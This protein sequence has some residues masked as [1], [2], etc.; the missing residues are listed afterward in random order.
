MTVRNINLC[1]WNCQ[2]AKSNCHWLLKV[3]DNFDII[4]IQETWLFDYEN[5]LLKFS[6][7]HNVIA[8]SSMRNDKKLTGR[9]FGG[10]AFLIKT[11]L[12]S[13]IKIVETND[14]RLLAITVELANGDNLLVVNVYF[15]VNCAN[16][17][18][19]I[20]EYIAKTNALIVNHSGPV[21]V[22]G[23]LNISEKHKNFAELIEFCKSS[24]CHLIDLERLSPKTV[25]YESQSHCSSSWID[26]IIITANLL[27]KVQKVE[28]LYEATPSDHF[29]LTIS[30]HINVNRESTTGRIANVKSK[31]SIVN[32]K[33]VPP[34]VIQN[35]TNLTR[36]NISKI[37]KWELCTN[38][39]CCNTEHCQNIDDISLLLTST[40]LSHQNEVFTS[41]I[42][43]QHTSRAY[44]KVGWNDQVKVKYQDYRYWFLKWTSSN[45]KDEI[46][47]QQMKVKRKAFKTALK[48]IRQKNET[49]LCDKLATSYDDN[50]FYEFWKNVKSTKQTSSPTTT[51]IENANGDNQIC[52]M[53][54]THYENIFASSSKVEHVC[55]NKHCETSENWKVSPEEIVECL[56]QL[57]NGKAAGIDGL[58]A[59]SY[60]F[61]SRN[62][63]SVIANIFNS[64][65]A[66][67][68]LPSEI[69]KFILCPILKKPSLDPTITKNYRP[70][71]LA[72]V[73]SKVFELLILTRHKVKFQ[74]STSQFG[75]KK[76]VGT[77][78]AIFTLKQVAHHYLRKGSPVY[79]CY[80]DA[81][82]A[83]DN[84]E[85]SKLLCKLC[86]RNVGRDTI[87]LLKFWFNNQQ[88]LC[89][90][91][92]I[93]SDPFY[94][95]KATR[96]G[97]IISPYYFA[98][99]MENL[100]LQL[101]K[102]GLGCKVGS[103]SCNHII[104]ADDVALM[105]TSISSL[106]RMLKLCE[107]F[108]V[109][110][111]ITFNPSK[112]ILQ[113]FTPKYMDYVRPLVKFCGKN[114]Q[115]AESVKY[116]GYDICCWDRDKNELVKRKREIYMQANL[117]KSFFKKCSKNVKKYLFT[118]YFSSIYCASLWCPN[119]NDALRSLKVAYNDSCRIIFGYS[120]RH[121]A[122]AM[123]CENGIKDFD[124]IRRTSIYSLIRR[125]CTTDN[126]ILREIFNSNILLD[127]SL[128][129]SWCDLVL[130]HPNESDLRTVTSHN[131]TP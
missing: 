2:G 18:K 88:F 26:H 106:K 86:E 10:L 93:L 43:R 81:T 39:N 9:L 40:L 11:D 109:Q 113:A 58:T 120:R 59:E 97:G 100:C 89:R 5:N 61:A 60:K 84:V 65:I 17:Q 96:Q 19:Q 124:T 28:V 85:L 47:F 25:T 56:K 49:I 102:S 53:W 15:P 45:K 32:W 71:A 27:Q 3:I 64:C 37:E 66:H 118:T 73:M 20:S 125:L 1:T 22:L 29:P 131:D 63:C 51:V 50:N 41:Y 54:K 79:I 111:N 33:R 92:G 75:Y 103:L 87:N 7:N 13:S 72:T 70:I 52:D 74:T 115:W 78:T 107:E 108:A 68:Y 14:T 12:S 48:S 82:A 46:A 34:T 91:K 128:Y 80:L 24:D 114:I 104:Y 8:K 99:Y 129:R 101:N 4:A 77:E 90:W 105:T 57:K 67:S 98:I 76:G 42:A 31:C 36:D 130:A 127:S 35:Y 6:N 23:D 126:E 55:K 117:V 123:F 83:F 44:H 62:V 95:R 122:S 112:T 69:M 121:S 94:V 16:N 38:S 119:N 110:H 116:L 30:L 21:V